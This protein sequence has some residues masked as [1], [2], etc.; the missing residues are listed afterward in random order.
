[1]DGSRSSR[2]AARS[3]LFFFSFSFLFFVFFFSSVRFIILGTVEQHRSVSD[4][5]FL[6]L[7]SREGK[8]QSWAPDERVGNFIPKKNVDSCAI[9]FSMWEACA[10][11][12]VVCC[13][14]V[15][16]FR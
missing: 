14:V 7:F 13:S 4:F 16:N 11:C 6:F 9:L 15:W 12:A 10:S 3:I 2:L 8:V 5:Y 1:M